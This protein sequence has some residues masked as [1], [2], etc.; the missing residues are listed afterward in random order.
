MVTFLLFVSVVATTSLLLA[1]V[2]DEGFT[3][4]LRA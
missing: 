4:A 1:V 2:A 3:S